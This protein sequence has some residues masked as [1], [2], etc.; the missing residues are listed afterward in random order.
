MVGNYDIICINQEKDS[1]FVNI[2]H[3]DKFD[4]ITLISGSA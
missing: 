4:E 1:Y 3:I 2:N